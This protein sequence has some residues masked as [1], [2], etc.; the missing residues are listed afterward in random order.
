M[1]KVLKSKLFIGLVTAGLSAS[2]LAVSLLFGTLARTSAAASNGTTRT[3]EGSWL[4]SVTA[5]AGQQTEMFQLLETYDAGGGLVETDQ[6]DFQ[7]QFSTSPGH[8]A[9]TSRGADDFASTWLA[10][11]FD[12]K[13]NPAGTEKIREVDTL[14]KGGDA[15]NGSGKF[16][17]VDVK[18]NVLE[19][20]TFTAHATRIHVE[21]V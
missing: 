18:G 10:F 21:G 15:Y 2:I 8:G 19:A 4:V 14:S 7:P 12:A 5:R 1:K 16:T 9:L 11:F 20:G 13:G 3:P 17:I 6:T